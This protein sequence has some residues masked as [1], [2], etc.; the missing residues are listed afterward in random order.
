MRFSSLVLSSLSALNAKNIF[1][2]FILLFRKELS[3]HEKKVINAGVIN[4]IELFREWYGGNGI[5]I[6]VKN[7]VG[8]LRIVSFLKK[9]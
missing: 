7:N 3:I 6:H 4:K 1:H 5:E 8:Q 9:K 2:F